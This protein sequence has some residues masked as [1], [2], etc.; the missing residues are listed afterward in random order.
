[1][2]KGKGKMTRKM[3]AGA[4]FGFNFFGT[5]VTKNAC[6]YFINSIYRDYIPKRKIAVKKNYNLLIDDIQKIL[7][8]ED[9]IFANE[10]DR[11]IIYN[12]VVGYFKTKNYDLKKLIKYIN[13]FNNKLNIELNEKVI[14]LTHYAIEEEILNSNLAE[15]KKP[16]DCAYLSEKLRDIATNNDKKLIEKINYDIQTSRIKN[17]PGIKYF[18]SDASTQKYVPPIKTKAREKFFGIFGG[19]PIKDERLSIYG[20]IADILKGS[21]DKTN[22]SSAESI[23][24]YIESLSKITEILKILKEQK[25]QLVESK[26]QLADLK[27]INTSLPLQQL[28]STTTEEYIVDSAPELIDNTTPTE[29]QLQMRPQKPP[30]P[31]GRSTSIT[32]LLTTAPESTSI[33]TV[34]PRL[35]KKTTTPII[36]QE[37]ST[38]DT[39]ESECPK[40]ETYNIMRRSC[41]P[42]LPFASAL[43]SNQ[44]KTKSVTPLIPL[45][46]VPNF[47]SQIKEGKE[48]NKQKSLP[49]S[50]EPPENKDPFSEL[51][52]SQP[53]QQILNRRIYT[54]PEVVEDDD[55]NEWNDGGGKKRRPHSKKSNKK[56]PKKSNKKSHKK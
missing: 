36:S 42:V 32:P 11:L 16:E 45:A 54:K 2:N 4:P 28:E 5:K 50:N 10:K 44:Q 29:I 40:G 6:D 9:K 13:I 22:V 17:L 19:D 47:L 18:K 38:N 37:K 56:H 30:P 12:S 27:N 34:A 52:K 7:R 8:E 31:P 3:R 25:E 41:V 26:E 14:N 51:S 24:N 15:L 46:P 55:D 43:T 21:G 53:L 20:E 48:L 23:T 39:A 33:L 49:E 35:L 1:M